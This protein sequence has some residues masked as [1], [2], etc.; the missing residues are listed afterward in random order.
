MS[1]LDYDGNYVDPTKNDAARVDPKFNLHRSG[2]GKYVQTIPYT[3]LVNIVDSDSLTVLAE[4]C[5]QPNEFMAT[6]QK[7]TYGPEL[8][9]VLMRIMIKLTTIPL[10]ETVRQ[11][12]FI[13]LAQDH[14]WEQ[15]TKFFDQPSENEKKKKR[16]KSIIVRPAIGRAE[17]VEVLIKFLTQVKLYHPLNHAATALCKNLH[18][19]AI[20][21]DT[22]IR[23]GL[24][25]ITA[26]SDDEWLGKMTVS[27]LTSRT[28]DH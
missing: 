3:K 4:I 13:L 7:R 10:H 14:F 21:I 28:V 12:C 8:M 23:D 20:D 1:S 5:L 18:K 24:A 11:Y 16:K 19:N 26:T 27:N 2:P 9:L 25:Q 15:L 6:L 22:A 17:M